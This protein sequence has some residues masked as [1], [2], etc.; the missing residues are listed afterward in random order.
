[1]FLFKYV[2]AECRT[3]I[4]LSQAPNETLEVLINSG[5][6]TR[7]RQACANH[8]SGECT[9]RKCTVRTYTGESLTPI[10]CLKIWETSLGQKFSVSVVETAVHFLQNSM[11]WL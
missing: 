3:K 8:P 7:P 11:Q 6:V 1:M 4:C 9:V 2:L 5:K 10:Q